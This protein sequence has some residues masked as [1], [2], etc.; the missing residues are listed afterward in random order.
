MQKYGGN[1]DFPAY[2]F[3][4]ADNGVRQAEMT[5]YAEWVAR[6][7]VFILA[8]FSALVI[9]SGRNAG[10]DLRMP[11]FLSVFTLGML[12]AFTSFG[13]PLFVLLTGIPVL[14]YF[15]GLMFT[16]FGDQTRGGF[17]FSLLPALLFMGVILS[18]VS[19][20]GPY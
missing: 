19:V 9:R 1:L 11:L 20:I 7:L 2:N 3:K 6:T 12:E 4:M 13:A 18:V 5:G 17:A 8:M 16:V 15:L 10:S 14:L